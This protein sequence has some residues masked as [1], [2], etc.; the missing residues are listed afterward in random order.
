MARHLANSIA[1]NLIL[2][3]E[4]HTTVSYGDCIHEGFI[5]VTDRTELCI[6]DAKAEINKFGSTFDLKLMFGKH[7]I[8]VWLHYRDRPLPVFSNDQ[9]IELGNIGLLCIDISSFN[10]KTFAKEKRRFSEAVQDFLLHSGERKWIHHPKTGAAVEAEKK[11]HNCKW[12]STISKAR[13]SHKESNEFDF[14]DQ[15][16][17]NTNFQAQRI[18][19]IPEP[20][21]YQC[22][23]CKAEWV[24]NIHGSPSCPRGCG[25]LYSRKLG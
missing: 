6:D 11:I 10:Q 17:L 22:A 14:I 4:L 16:A 2:L 12:E 25:H 21:N 13:R 5:K 9:R 23:I 18:P 20:T 1:G 8:L 24:H 19:G 3:P 15:T 7:C